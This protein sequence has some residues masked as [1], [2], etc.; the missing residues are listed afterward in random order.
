[1]PA[2]RFADFALEWVSAFNAHDLFRILSHYRADVELVSPLYQRFTGG[3]SDCV[4]G[5]EALEAYFHAALHRYPDLAFEL[6]D[7]ADGARGPCLRY[8]S[9][10]DRRVAMEAFELDENG[11]AFRVMCHYVGG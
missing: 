3:L 7:I 8:R 4:Q 1:M 11:K 10:L 9:S 2:P 6:I 5:I